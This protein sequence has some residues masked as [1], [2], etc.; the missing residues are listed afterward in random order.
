MASGETYSQV[1]RLT[2]VVTTVGS[3]AQPQ[4]RAVGLNVTQALAV[5][6]LLSLGC[7]WKGAL[8]GLVSWL[9]AVVAQ[10]LCGGTNL[11][12]VAN[13]ATLITGTTSK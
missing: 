3:S 5:V 6:A 1:T 11:R 2:A 8:V 4:G 10:T 7:P 9:L 13:I 12:I